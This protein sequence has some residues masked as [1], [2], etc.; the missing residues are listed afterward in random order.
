[1]G[2]QQFWVHNRKGA[3]SIQSLS[4]PQPFPNGHLASRTGL[5]HGS[6]PLARPQMGER[7]HAE[8]LVFSLVPHRLSRMTPTP[9]FHFAVSKFPGA[10]TT[11]NPTTTGAMG[12][13]NQNNPDYTIVHQ[14]LYHPG[15]LSLQASVCILYPPPY[16]LPVLW[17]ALALS[18][19]PAC[20]KAHEASQ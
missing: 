12:W 9:A 8:P 15:S 1:M 14:A 4:P 16:P 17:E 11:Q 10:V 19:E 20:C 13:G 7:L 5:T 3:E 18:L 2:V 6:V